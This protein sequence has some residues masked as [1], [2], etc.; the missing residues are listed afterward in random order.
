MP[1][2][3][4]SHI[5]QEIRIL[6]LDVGDKRIGLAVSDPLGLTAQGL[7]VLHRQDPVNDLA[8]LRQ[9]AEGYRV[10]EIVVGLPRHMNGRPAATATKIVELAKNLADA[11]GVPLTTWDE[12]LST[13]EAEKLLIS[14]DLSRRRRR[15]VIDQLSAVLILQSYLDYRQT[16]SHKPEPAD[17]S[18]R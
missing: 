5:V 6:A 15:Q 3:N 14:A 7:Q 12:R 16:V 4:M 10:Q 2:V 17:P 11:L 13:A 1:A 18:A 9:L 8:R